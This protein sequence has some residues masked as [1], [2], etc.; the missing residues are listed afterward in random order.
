MLREQYPGVFTADEALALALH[1]ENIKRDCGPYDPAWK[2][3]SYEQQAME[4]M[5][6]LLEKWA[7][8]KAESA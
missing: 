3:F 8:A 5:A 2:R 1:A 4:T 6:L 7:A